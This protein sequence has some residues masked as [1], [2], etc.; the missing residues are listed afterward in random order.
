MESRPPTSSGCGDTDLAIYPINL[1][2]VAT[3]L[4]QHGYIVVHRG[5]WWWFETLA[6]RK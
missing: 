4:V 6:L 1:A 3:N 2:K 5:P